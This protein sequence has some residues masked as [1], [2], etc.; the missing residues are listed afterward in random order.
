MKL[1]F[2]N[3]FSHE[4]DIHFWI[5]IIGPPHCCSYSSSNLVRMQ[6]KKSYEVMP[7]FTH[8]II[9]FKLPIKHGL[10]GRTM[11]QRH[12]DFKDNS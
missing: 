5:C 2:S 1:I 7:N 10:L 9:T 3:W 4:F 8:F 12:G 11:A 6:P